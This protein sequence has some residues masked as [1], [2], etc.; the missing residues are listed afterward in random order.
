[1][2]RCYTSINYLIKNDLSLSSPDSDSDEEKFKDSCY[3]L[4]K[5][6]YVPKGIRN[7]SLNCYM[8]SLLQCLFNIPELR[9]YFIDGLKNKKFQKKSTPICYYF[10]KVMK[11]LFYSNQNYITPDKFKKI[12]SE[13]MLYL[14][15]VKPQMQQTYL[16]M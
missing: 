8:D 16:E 10:A 11:N 15:S 2:G 4:I 12:I 5:E 3:N 7:L 13:K 6:E 9:K 1:M 14:K